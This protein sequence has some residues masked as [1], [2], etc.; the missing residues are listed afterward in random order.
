MN[1]TIEVENLEEMQEHIKSLEDRIVEESTEIIIE[2]TIMVEV[3]I[4]TGLGK[5]SFSR[6]FSNRRKDRSTSNSRSKL[7]LRAKYQQRQ[8]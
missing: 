6:N 7:G 3:E 4:G 1:K 8:N 5:L 2:M